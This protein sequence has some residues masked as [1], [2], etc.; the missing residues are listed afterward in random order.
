MPDC[1]L[2]ELPYQDRRT[3]GAS[4]LDLPA[5]S[6][7]RV[8]F[9]RKFGKRFIVFVDTEEEFDWN[10]PRSREATNTSAVRH[11]PEFQSLMDAHGTAPCYL[12]DYPVAANPE[13]AETMASLLADGRC[14]VG[15]QLHPWVNPPFDEEVV[16]HNSFAGNLPVEQER[17]KLKVLTEK[18]ETA[19]GC[20]PICYRAGRYGIGPH[21]TDLLSELGYRVDTSVRPAF[22]YAHEGGPSFLKHDA[23]PYWGGLQSMLIELP[24]GATY[25]GQLRRYGRWLIGDGRTNPKRIAALSRFGLCARV[26]LTPE[27]MPLRDVER[28]IRWM[29]KDGIQLFSFSFHSPSLVPGNTPYVRNSGE[30]ND[31]YRWWDRIFAVLASHGIAPASLDDVIEAAWGTRAAPRR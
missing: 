2:Q 10:L 25:T 1:V 16:T 30:L 20:R 5:R 15:T 14:S 22:D 24:L 13:S 8:R 23:R 21:T 3:L 6:A 27:D 31:F 18:I 4:R 12:I 11:L 28:A 19:V 17:E 9:D 29:L 26:A 7:D